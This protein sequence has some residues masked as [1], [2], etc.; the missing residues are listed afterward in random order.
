MRI[1]TLFIDM[2]RPSRLSSFNEKVTVDTPLDTVFKEM[3]GTF[4]PNCFTPGP[5]TPRGIS[6]YLTGV[7]PYQNGCSTRLKW[8]QYFLNK[9]LLTVFDLFL[10]KDYAIQCFSSPAERNT[11]LFP[12][13]IADMDIHNEDYDMGKYLSNIELKKDHFLFVS[14]PDY[15]WAF[16]DYG[17]SEHGEKEAYKVT[18]SACDIVFESLNKD[19]FDHIFVFSD[20]GFKFSS[21]KALQPKEYMLDA[22]RANCLLIHR[23]KNQQEIVKDKRLCSLTDLYAS[24]QDIL[25]ADTGKGFSVLSENER[26]HVVLEDHV[27]FAPAINQNIDLWGL[28]TKEVTYIRTLTGA[29]LIDRESNVINREVNDGHDAVLKECSSFGVYI[30]EYEKVFRYKDNILSKSVYMNGVTRKT[31]SSLY[32]YFYIVIDTIRYYIGKKK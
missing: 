8:P 12:Q 21:E 27:D 15:H 19:D 5:D 25:E 9:K 11:G 7:N 20:H 6:S 16:D 10:E 14:I 13:H 31:K 30:D 26:T 4:Y 22:N 17:Y 32:K 1:L 23:E 28:V 29:M 24:Y 3:G 2:I 18:K